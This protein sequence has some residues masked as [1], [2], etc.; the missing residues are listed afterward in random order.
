ML[1][2]INSG[3]KVYLCIILSFTITFVFE[4][5]ASA[6][7]EAGTM[8]SYTR[9]GWA[10]ARYVAMGKAA[11]A[12]VDD[13]YAIYWN[14]A[15]L[16]ELKQKEAISSEDIRKKA[17]TGDIDS[18]TEKD[19]TRFSEDNYSKSFLQIGISSAFLDVDRE[20]GFAGV[21]FSA[22]QGVMGIGYYGIQSRKI[23]SYDTNGNYIKDLNYT[24]S[25]AFLSY[26]WGTGI[27]SMGVSLKA[28]YENIG[29][30]N[31]YGFGSDIGTQI[32][33]IPL[34]KVGFVIQD[35]GTGLKP[36]ENYNNISNKYD[37]AYP[38][39][40]LSGSVTNRG[41]D[42]VAVISCVKKLEQNKFEVNFGFQYNIFKYTS[43][44]L[45]LNDSL[46]STGLSLKVGN[47][48]F[49]YAI[50]FDKINYGYNNMISVTLVI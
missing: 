32:E 28:L 14:P 41:G 47:L 46:F 39:F 35:I 16:R 38:V 26:G 36:A 49:T 13:V 5:N 25:I 4:I 12:V 6:D 17:E 48:D 29:R 8:A 44:Y 43:L 19:L 37:F 3:L 40:K 27:A 22:F 45:G 11:E 42:I 23:E 10:G 20:A 33:L 24:G 30:Y 2:I 31:Y 15:G 21:A 9:S 18:I 7:N 50:S 34:V 1:K